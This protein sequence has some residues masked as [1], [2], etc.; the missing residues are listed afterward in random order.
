MPVNRSQTIY[1]KGGLAKSRGGLS[2]TFR[3]SQ[4]QSLTLLPNE[5]ALRV[6]L[7]RFHAELRF[8]NVH[9]QNNKLAWIRNNGTA[10]ELVL[11]AKQYDTLTSLAGALED[12]IKDKV[13]SA[14]TV[15]VIADYKLKIVFTSL[16]ANNNTGFFSS[17]R[18]HL[19]LGGIQNTSGEGAYGIASTELFL[20]TVDGTNTGF[21]SVCPCILYEMRHWYLRSSLNTDHLSSQS[22]QIMQASDKI[23]D[24][25]NAIVTA[26]NI[27]ASMVESRNSSF[28]EY[29]E[30]DGGDFGMVLPQRNMSAIQFNL[31]DGFGV[32]LTSYL[33]SP[34]VQYVRFH[35]TLRVQALINEPQMPIP[36][37]R[38]ESALEL[39]RR[40]PMR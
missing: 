8:F 32:P 40:M 26:S 10:V 29:N 24:E 3:F 1:L 14:V 25:S 11:P 35:V 18:A 34:Y 4:P 21:E 39:D 16:D 20:R 36:A 23:T 5:S 9:E 37:S 13:S 6:K 38:G 17:S 22:L 31:T 15:S 33:S 12:V 19:L 7:V 28:V 2:E 27:L 30:V